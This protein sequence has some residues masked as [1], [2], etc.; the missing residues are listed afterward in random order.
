MLDVKAFCE[1][2]GSMWLCVD[3]PGPPKPP[4][5]SEIVD[6]EGT[7]PLRRK[8]LYGNMNN[9]DLHLLVSDNSFLL[10]LDTKKAHTPRPLLLK[11][12]YIAMWLAARH[13]VSNSKAVVVF[14]LFCFVTSMLLAKIW[15][16]RL[17]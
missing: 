3:F 17:T 16:Q 4:S 7:K 6:V 11:V 15:R 13:S 5:V 14:F 12:G 10:S 9:N 2:L 8:L 1:L